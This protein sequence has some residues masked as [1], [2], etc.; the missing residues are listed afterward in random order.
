MIRVHHLNIVVHFLAAIGGDLGF[1][2]IAGQ[3]LVLLERQQLLLAEEQHDML[4]MRIADRID[5]VPAQRL[6]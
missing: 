5:L 1:T 4:A 6:R 2:E 3:R